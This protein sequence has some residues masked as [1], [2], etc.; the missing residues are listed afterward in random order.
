MSF[1]PPLKEFVHQAMSSA[2]QAAGHDAAKEGT[3]SQAEGG[4]GGGG[5]GGEAGSL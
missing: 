4:L 5:L 3:E 2:V 1:T